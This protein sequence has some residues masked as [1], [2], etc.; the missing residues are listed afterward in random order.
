MKRTARRL[1]AGGVITAIICAASAGSAKAEGTIRQFG[2]GGQAQ[3]GFIPSD[4]GGAVGNGYVMQT[5]NGIVSIFDAKTGQTVSRTTLGQFWGSLGVQTNP[6]QGNYMSDPRV[7]F[8]PGTNRWFTSAITT[9]AVNQVGIAVSKGA[10]PLGG[11]TALSFNAQGNQFYDFPTLGVNHAA[12]TIGTNNFSNTSGYFDGSGLFSI[13]KQDLTGAKPSL[14]NMTRFDSLP[15]LDFTN[16]PVTD[17]HGGTSTTVLTSLNNPNLPAFGGEGILNLSNVNTSH[18]AL[19]TGP[20]LDNPLD[21]NNLVNPVQPGGTPYD[22]NDPRISASPVQVGTLIYFTNSVQQGGTDDLYWGVIDAADQKLVRSGTVGIPGL[23]LT[24]PSIAANGDGVFVI[25][26]N[27][28]GTGTDISA[29][30]V[31]CSEYTGACGAPAELYAGTGNSYAGYRGDA[32]WGDYSAIVNDPY[33]ANDFWLFQ[34]YA[35]KPDLWGTVIT[36]FDV[37]EPGSLLLLATGLLGLGLVCR[38]RRR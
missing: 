17:W 30:N 8:D 6:A 4:M 2:G 16:Q 25:G 1:A 14:A 7:V 27:G 28:S 15:S 38:I 5:V 10:S 3:A 12:V 22:A 20:S 31:V 29:Y 21:Y 23:D 26:F 37:P 36:E 9:A 13:P 19:S 18:A 11:F 32:R 35:T 34:D 33:N 24:F